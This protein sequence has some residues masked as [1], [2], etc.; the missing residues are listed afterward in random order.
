MHK[1]TGLLTA[2]FILA[3]MAVPQ[4]TPAELEKAV[5]KVGGAL[6][7]SFCAYGLDK[8]VKRHADAERSVTN[9]R[10]AITV[11]TFKK[12]KSIDLAK[13]VEVFDR[14]G[15]KPLEMIV[16]ARGRLVGPSTFEASGT[17]QQFKLADN[18]QLKQ[19]NTAFKEQEVTLTARV[20]LETFVWAIEDIQTP[21]TERP[22]HEH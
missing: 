17:G 4:S 2:L 16:T 15:F 3:F 12:D 1:T 8:V 11:V 13:V 21:S 6:G 19:L 9:W 22:L 7:C 10:K 14:A 5:V 18:E 20:D